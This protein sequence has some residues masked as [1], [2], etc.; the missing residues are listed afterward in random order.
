MYC[1]FTP[2]SYPIIYK[3][4]FQTCLAPSKYVFDTTLSDSK[5]SNIHCDHRKDMDNC[6]TPIESST[7]QS[8][9]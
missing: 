5:S 9:A 3:A 4:L 6:E 7:Y 1:K 8:Y 2:S